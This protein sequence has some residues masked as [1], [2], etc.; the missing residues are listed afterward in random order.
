MKE[1]FF[2]YTKLFFSLLFSVTYPVFWNYTVRHYHSHLHS[3]L[4]NFENFQYLHRTVFFFRKNDN[5][6]LYNERVFCK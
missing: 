1:I 6:V 2:F 3:S 5:D 4:R